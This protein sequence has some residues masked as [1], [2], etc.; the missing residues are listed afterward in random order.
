ML[1]PIPWMAFGSKL[2]QEI[3]P[4][5][6]FN[7]PFYW[8]I[9]VRLKDYATRYPSA[10]TFGNSKMVFFQRKAAK[11]KLSANGVKSR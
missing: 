3:L 2:N 6:D 8:T 4:R 10:A 5:P 7:A 11:A 9:L 1:P